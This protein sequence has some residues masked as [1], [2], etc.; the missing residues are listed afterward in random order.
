[1]SGGSAV[2]VWWTLKKSCLNENLV[3]AFQ[4]VA[5]SEEAIGCYKTLITLSL[6]FF[7]A[8]IGFANKL[9]LWIKN[10]VRHLK[11]IG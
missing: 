7:T 10:R 8:Y 6:A 4:L 11:L 3:V 1:M 9:P 2:V 5:L